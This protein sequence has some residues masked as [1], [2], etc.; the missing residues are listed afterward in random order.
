MTTKTYKKIPNTLPIFDQK[1]GLEFGVYSLGEHL[2]N[3]HT[4]DILTAQ[5][6]I[7]QIKEMA[8]LS[9]QAGLDVFMLGESHQEGFVSQAHA[10][11]LGAIAEAT[12]KIKISSGATIMSTSDPVRVFENFST[13]DL[14]SNGRIEIVGGRASRIGLFKL[15]GFDLNNYEELFEEKFDLLLQ[16]N[17][18]ER[19][20]WQGNFRAP[21]E[22]ALILPRPIN[23]HLPIWRA[24]GGGESSAV[25]AGHAGVPMNIAML[26]GPVSSFKRTID[27]YRESARMAGFDENELPVAAG[28]LFYIAKDMDTALREFYPHVNHGIFKSNGQGFP[29]QAFAHARDPKS[30]MNIGEVNQVI[31]KI[32]YQHEEFGHQRYMAQLDFGGV[33]FEKIME[34]IDVLGNKVLPAVRKYTTPKENN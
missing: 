14:L 21:L 2:L 5:E 1:K 13:L 24:V 7:N 8:V 17:R 32:I 9:E 19:I 31:E 33:P 20:T 3:P 25:K 34:N 18:Q 6:R 4:N 16:L 27:V 30:V 23:N 11:I 28:G 29:K 15:L 26:G 10:V 12:K 22:D